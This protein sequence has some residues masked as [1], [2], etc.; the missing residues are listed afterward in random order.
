M[1]KLVQIV[2]YARTAQQAEGLAEGFAVLD[3][4]PGAA[5]PYRAIPEQL[6]L[7][8]GSERCARRL[9]DEA[10]ALI[11]GQAQTERRGTLWKSGS[12][13]GTRIGAGLVG[14]QHRGPR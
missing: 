10:R 13:D 4:E 1:G 3:S 11:L 14:R 5:R 9:A 7:K 2:R 12:G 8:V 6:G